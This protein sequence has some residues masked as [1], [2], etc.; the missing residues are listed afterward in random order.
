MSKVTKGTGAGII[1]ILLSALV[2]RLLARSA[3]KPEP[4]RQRRPRMRKA[5]LYAAYARAEQDPA[6]MEEMREAAS[7]W[8]RTATD[9]LQPVSNPA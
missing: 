9:G 6:Y 8:D 2:E 4:K 7:V 5:D 3:P 1:V